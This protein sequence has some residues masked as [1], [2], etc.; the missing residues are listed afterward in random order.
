MTY[1]NALDERN[2][3]QVL[4]A[5][6][7]RKGLGFRKLFWTTGLITFFLSPLA[8]NLTSAL[9]MSTVALAVSNGNARFMFQRSLIS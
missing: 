8:D 2:V 6:L 7:L 4:R 3:F 9:L 5:W 1:I